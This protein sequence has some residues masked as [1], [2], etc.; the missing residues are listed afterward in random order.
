MSALVAAVAVGASA[1]VSAGASIYSASKSSKAARNAA[2][3]QREAAERAME[4]ETRR[5]EE[6]KALVAPYVNAGTAS[7]GAQQNLIGLSGAEKQKAA[8]DALQN[9]EQFKATFQQGENAILQ[10]A[11]ATG[12]LRGGNIQ[13]ALAQFRPQVLSAM[14]NDQYAKLQGITGIGQAAAA[15][16]AAATQQQGRDMAALQ[17]QIGAA[18]ASGLLGSANAWNQGIGAAAGQFSN[19]ANSFAGISFL[20]QNK[21]GGRFGGAQGGFEQTFGAGT[22]PEG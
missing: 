12:G 10:N 20:N 15:G 9:S 13:A 6:L 18:N 7:I 4:E 19:A 5:F 2:D 16:Q 8:I 11:S 1:V 3:Q 17:N 21:G 22:S 14:I